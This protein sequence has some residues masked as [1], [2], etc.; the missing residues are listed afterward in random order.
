MHLSLVTPPSLISPLDSSSASSHRKGTASLFPWRLMLAY[1]AL[2]K[3]FH[4]TWPSIQTTLRLPSVKLLSGQGLL[5]ATFV[6]YFLGC[7]S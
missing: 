5:H 6:N 3:S 7:R 4:G 1:V 2:V